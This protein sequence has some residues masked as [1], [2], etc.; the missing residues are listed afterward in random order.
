MATTPFP[1][2]P[3]AAAA[4]TP[5]PAQAAGRSHPAIRGAVLGNYVDQFDI[6]LPVI[7]LAPA[8]AQLYGT[9]NAAA[10]AGFIFI[11]TLLGRPVGAAVFGPLADRSGRTRTTRISIA[12]VAVVTLLI[13]AVPAG[14]GHATLLAIIVLRFLGGA[15]IGGGYTAA[16]PLAMEWAP[17][18]RRG[19]VSGQIMSMSPWAN[20]SIAAL[21][22]VLLST[23]GPDAYAHWAWR[24][25]FLLGAAMTFA[26]YLYYRRQV[27]DYPLPERKPGTPQ[28]LRQAFTGRGGRALAQLFVLMTG[29]WLFTNMG[30]VVLAGQLKATAGL[31]DRAVSLTMFCATVASALAMVATGH[32]STGTGRRRFFLWFGA[33]AALLAPA[34]YLGVFS[35]GPLAAVILLVGLLQVVTVSAY[36]PIGA[37]LTERFPAGARSTG[38][39]LAYSLSIVL[40]ALYPYY[41]P[42]LQRAFG[43]VPAVA[44]L[45]ALAG[46]CVLAGALA[47]R[48]S[49][50]PEPAQR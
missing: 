40:P 7:A 48:A 36:G 10:A 21:V 3:L 45:L 41:L 30:V 43:A 33:A 31:D 14:F 2:A 5:V 4:G 42:P 16:V 20:A 38:Y 46:L 28:P 6:F 18:S 13:G 39:G 44:G 27:R 35:A 49:R 8:A 37:Y 32:L 17:G 11:A 47:D 29:L 19:L 23:L 34:T 22:L 12:G 25:P 1:E 26:L 9:G 15:F 50:L 24:I